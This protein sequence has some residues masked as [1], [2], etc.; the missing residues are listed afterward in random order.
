MH[1]V[2]ES[3]RSL[4]R[5]AERGEDGLFDVSAP[6]PVGAYVQ[7][8]WHRRDFVLQV[9]LG[10]LRAQT[11]STVLGGLWHLLNPVFFAAVYYFVFGV[12]FRGREDIP[13]YL[14]FLIAGLFS[15]LYIQRAA[16]TGAKSVTGNRGLI[17]QVNFPRAA[18]PIAAVIAE[19]ISYSW[20]IL[21]LGFLVVLTGEPVTWSWMLLVPIV[22]LQMLFNTGFAMVVARLAFHFRDIEQF[23]PYLLRMWMY[24]SGI[25]FT[26]GFVES[27]LG[28]SSPAVAL[29]ELNPAYV[30]ATLTRAAVLK[31][32]AADLSVWLIGTAWAAGLLAGGFL[33][34]RGREVEYANE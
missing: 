21:A 9:P 15:F 1:S 5:T 31:D 11:H 26:V 20:S 14:G 32:H 19:T 27:R 10:R 18:L 24:L 3:N 28:P 17:G 7:A 16:Q 12:I 33:Y 29:F 6:L 34:F 2:V 8:L 23:L 13:N 22:I 4:L 25:F 30:Y